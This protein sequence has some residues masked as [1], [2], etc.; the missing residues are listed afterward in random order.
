MGGNGKMSQERIPNVRSTSGSIGL[1]ASDNDRDLI[2][3][4]HQLIADGIFGVSN[5]TQ[6]GSATL[7]ARYLHSVGI[8][9]SNYWMFLRMLETNNR[10]VVDALCGERD[11]RLLFSIVKPSGEL[12]DRAFQLITLWHPGE[13]YEKVL[14]AIMG[15]IE[16]SFHAADEGLSFHPLDISDI[17]NIGK[18]LNTEK[19]QFDPVNSVVLDILYWITHLGTYEAHLRKSVLAKHA[20]HVRMAFFDN[21]K[22]LTD[23]IPQV[24][25]VRIDRE[26]NEIKPQKEFIE[27]LENLRHT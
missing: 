6:V 7:F 23:V 21:T 18:H 24:L 16:L 25:L 3:K 8:T 9:P 5:P 26:Q 12:L 11:P 22:R 10:Y 1:R 2:R 14:S 4:N 15:I 20:Y 17:N 13:I 27:F 19:D